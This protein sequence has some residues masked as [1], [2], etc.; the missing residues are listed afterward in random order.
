MCKKNV[1]LFTF[2]KRENKI[3]E[4]HKENTKGKGVVVVV[5]ELFQKNKGEFRFEKINN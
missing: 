3:K 4:I 2:K 1:C 5:E